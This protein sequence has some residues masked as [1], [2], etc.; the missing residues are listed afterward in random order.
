MRSS[1]S[2]TSSVSADVRHRQTAPVD[3]SGRGVSAMD[4]SVPW[5]RVPAYPEKFELR[6]ELD[7][8]RANIGAAALSSVRSSRPA[9][10]LAGAGRCSNRARRGMDGTGGGTRTPD[11]R[12]WSRVQGRSSL[13]QTAHP[14]PSS[15]QMP[16]RG[17]QDETAVA[18]SG[19]CRVCSCVCKIVWPDPLIR[20]VAGTK[21]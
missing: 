11:R 19:N 10:K 13:R 2:T 6:A 20:A 17:S 12:F 15:V 8:P 7:A 4:T 1:A 3:G 21:A 5:P 9:K 18:S 16:R 14:V